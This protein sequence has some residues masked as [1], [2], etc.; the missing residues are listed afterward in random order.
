MYLF[1]NKKRQHVQIR[2]DQQSSR[3]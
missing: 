2:S 1:K 3:M